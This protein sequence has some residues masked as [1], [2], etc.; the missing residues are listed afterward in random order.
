MHGLRTSQCPDDDCTFMLLSV[1]QDIAL[2][3]NFGSIARLSDVTRISNNHDWR[4]SYNAT[5]WLTHTICSQYTRRNKEGMSTNTQQTIVPRNNNGFLH[6]R[7]IIML[8]KSIHETQRRQELH[9]A[10][11]IKRNTVPTFLFPQKLSSSVFCITTC[12]YVM[13]RL[14]TALFLSAISMSPS[15]QACHLALLYHSRCLLNR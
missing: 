12:N 13:H 3:F 10:Y 8:S 4:F 7:H 11:F 6:H 2:A 1:A 9:C 14:H 5:V 15:W